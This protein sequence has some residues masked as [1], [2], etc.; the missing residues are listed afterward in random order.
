MGKNILSC[1]VLLF[2]SRGI[3]ITVI[4][5]VYSDEVD[6]GSM[7][8]KQQFYSWHIPVLLFLALFTVSNRHREHL[9]AG[10]V[11]PRGG[12]GTGPPPKYAVDETPIVD[13]CQISVCFVHLC[14][15]YC[16]IMV[17]LPF[18]PSLTFPVILHWGLYCQ[19]G[20][21]VRSRIFFN[22]RAR[23]TNFTVDRRCCMPKSRTPGFGIESLATGGCCIY[24][25]CII[26]STICRAY[27]T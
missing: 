2:D 22:T 18:P 8:M 7:N 24:C 12:R 9:P 16:G 11:D 3:I 23:N 6:V 1:S 20:S 21:D 14:I 17:K 19:T 4:F 15:W 10:V 26:V 13:V 25:C 27:C 5:D